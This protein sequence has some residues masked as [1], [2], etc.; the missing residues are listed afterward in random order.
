LY[1]LALPE[2]HSVCAFGFAA[3]ANSSSL[4][5]ERRPLAMCVTIARAPGTGKTAVL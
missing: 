3:A 5:K 2:W 1:T 4:R